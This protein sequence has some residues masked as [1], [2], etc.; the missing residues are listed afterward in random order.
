MFLFIKPSSGHYLLYEGIFNV[1]LHY[2]IILFTQI[3]AKI[4]PVFKKIEIY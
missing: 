1:C 4:I 2:G 3:K